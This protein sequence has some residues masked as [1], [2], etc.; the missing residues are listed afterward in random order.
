MEIQE[1]RNEFIQ[2]LKKQEVDRSGRDFFQLADI[3]VHFQTFSTNNSLNFNDV[4]RKIRE[5]INEFINNNLLM[6]GNGAEE[7]M[8]FISLTNFGKDCL[9]EDDLIPYDPEGYINEIKQQIPKLDEIT[10]TYLK[11]SILTYNKRCILSSSITLGCASENLIN[12]AINHSLKLNDSSKEQLHYIAK[13]SKIKYISESFKIF[14]ER[15]KIL[16]NQNKLSC[17]INLDK[18]DGMFHFIRIN[19]NQSGHPTGNVPTI[20]AV[21]ANLQM[22]IEYAKE[23]HKIMNS[24]DLKT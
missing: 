8:P 7:G 12:E 3:R 19:R 10:L 2:F 24:M 1:I 16:K 18:V 13:I 21:Y 22:F 4:F 9:Q 20:K 11:E 5:I 17:E 23:I 15:V 6:W 14:K